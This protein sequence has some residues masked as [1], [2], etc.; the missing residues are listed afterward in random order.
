[1]L[2]IIC[3]EGEQHA[4]QHA[5]KKYFN[6]DQLSAKSVNNDPTF[7]FDLPNSHVEAMLSDRIS[8][9]LEMVGGKIGIGNVG[10]LPY[11]PSVAT[12]NL[13]QEIIML[14]DLDNE[15]NL[16]QSVTSTVPIYCNS[17]INNIRDLVAFADKINFPSQGIV[18]KQIV[19]GLTKNLKSGILTWDLL[20]ATVLQF[21]ST[22][23]ELVAETDM[24][25][26]LNPK[27]MNL[28]EHA[29][30]LLWQKYEFLLPS[31]PGN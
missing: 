18:L 9:A 4:L 19:N 25:T 21:S 31:T 1:M 20:Y 23:T 27:R 29:N 14:I 12:L 17:V 5:I 13:S 15:I 6:I 26:Y 3:A 11:Q 30:A 16:T 24:R 8:K 2:T 28:V 10:S 7:Y 22:G